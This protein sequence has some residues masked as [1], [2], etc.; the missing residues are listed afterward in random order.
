[1]VEQ[2]GLGA[3]A[4]NRQGEPTDALPGQK[5]EIIPGPGKGKYDK[6]EGV[7]ASERMREN[8]KRRFK[9]NQKTEG[10]GVFCE[11]CAATCN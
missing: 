7:P 9:E 1:M 11:D 6:G 4:M 3:A 8:I 2:K 10:Q 5:L